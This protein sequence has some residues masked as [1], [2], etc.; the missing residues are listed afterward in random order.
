MSWEVAVNQAVAAW[1]CC[2]N[3]QP[4]AVGREEPLMFSS[5]GR[6]GGTG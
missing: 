2:Y 3:L 4:F 5:A 6:E 1:V